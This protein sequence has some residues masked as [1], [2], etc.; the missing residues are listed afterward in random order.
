M[1]TTTLFSIIRESFLN[2]S[3]NDVIENSDY[4]EIIFSDASGKW[5]EMLFENGQYKFYQL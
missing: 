3:I 4:T 2:A 5:W 1:N